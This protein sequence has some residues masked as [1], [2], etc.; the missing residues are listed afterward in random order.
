[1]R[2]PLSKVRGLGA[3]KHGT[4]DYW[5]QRLTAAVM[6][7]LGVF[8]VIFLVAKAHGDVAAVRASLANPIVAILLAATVIAGALHMK[9]G[10]QVIIEDYVHAEPLKVTTIVLNTLFTALIVLGSIWAVAKLSFGM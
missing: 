5:K 4:E 2:T 9:I 8:L 3:A 1:M 7:P 6:V 10:M